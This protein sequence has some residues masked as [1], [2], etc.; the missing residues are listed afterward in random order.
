[1]MKNAIALIFILISSSLIAQ[2]GTASYYANKFEGRKTSSGEIFS[3]KKLTAAHKNLPFGTLLRVT[4]LSNDSVVVV[5]VNDRLPQSS[6]RM[7]DLSYAAA[8]QLNFI[9]KGLTKV[10]LEQVKEFKG[11]YYT[12]NDYLYYKGDIVTLS[13][14]LEDT[15][16]IVRERSLLLKL[17]T[18]VI[19]S[20]IDK[21]YKD[22]AWNHYMYFVHI[23]NDDSLRTQEE[24]F[25]AI[26]YLYKSLAIKENTAA[27][28]DL[29]HQL[30]LVGRCDEAEGLFKQYSFAL[31]E[32]S[33]LATLEGYL[34]HCKG[35][36]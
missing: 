16:T 7:I 2:E 36:K 27:I 34:L 14:G 1:M 13:C 22:L 26:S 18:T 12:A 5:K 4:N 20:N 15:V 17:D 30:T 33:L 3:Q 11:E 24:I 10:K 25:K 32:E 6:T 9:R 21:Y 23:Q 19:T 35:Q 31:Q 29:I 8:E 28:H